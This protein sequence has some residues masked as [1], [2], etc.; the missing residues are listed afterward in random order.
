MV[1][2]LEMLCSVFEMF[3]F[4]HSTRIVFYFAMIFSCFLDVKF[5]FITFDY[6]GRTFVVGRKLHL[7]VTLFF[8]V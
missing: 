7:G 1:V 3:E 8:D 6:D 4:H 5:S 2:G